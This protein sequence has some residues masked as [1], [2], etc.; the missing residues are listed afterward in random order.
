MTTEVTTPTEPTPGT[1]EYDALMAARGAQG[2]MNPE[3]ETPTPE[4]KEAPANV[5]D[6][7]APT[8]KLTDAPAGTETPT[9][10]P[11]SK[12]GDEAKTYDFA[13]AYSDGSLLTE[14]NAERPSEAMLASLAGA[15]GITVEQATEMQAA[16]RSGQQAL[17]A[18]AEQRMFEVAG[19]KEQFN[20]LI[21]WGQQNLPEADKA[22]YEQMLNGPDAATAIEILKTRMGASRDP[23]LVNVNAPQAPAAVGFRDQSEMIAAMADPRYQ[24][25]DAYRRDV[26]QKVRLSRF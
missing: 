24:S 25:S 21:A 7:N 15:L 13:K 6:P 12:E 5:V 1:P 22:R 19:G 2:T 3:I 16:Y 4:V 8:P 17:V 9:T 20:A 11:E 18:Q 26:E 14:F 23:S 10:P